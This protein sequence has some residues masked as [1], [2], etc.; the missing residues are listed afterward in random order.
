MLEASAV[1]KIEGDVFSPD[2]VQIVGHLFL[3]I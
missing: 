1:L 3:S 2:G